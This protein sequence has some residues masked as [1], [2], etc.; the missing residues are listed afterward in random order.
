MARF[1][2]EG[3]A[4]DYTP[5]ADVAAGDVVVIGASVGV[6]NQDIPANTLGALA[7]EGVFEMPKDATA[8]TAGDVVG[9]TGSVL[10]VGT[11]MMVVKDAAS[12]DSVAW[13]KLIPG[14]A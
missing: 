2:H 9:W 8:Y 4:I 6:A 5:V 10:G 3:N 7:I 14:A 11:S 1:I 13:C 12:G